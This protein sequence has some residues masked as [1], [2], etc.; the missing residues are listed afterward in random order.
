MKWLMLAET[1]PYKEQVSLVS[2]TKNHNKNLKTGKRG[3]G[4]R[5]KKIMTF[6]D[7][8]TAPW[9]GQKGQFFW[10]LRPKYSI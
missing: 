5:K 7:A 3:M 2:Q 8:P 9:F 4:P 1:R 6:H 10:P